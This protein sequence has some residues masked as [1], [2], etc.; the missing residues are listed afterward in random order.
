MRCSWTVAAAALF[1]ASGSSCGSPS[2]LVDRDMGPGLDFASYDAGVNNS[3]AAAA[4]GGTC[5]TT[6]VCANGNTDCQAGQACNMALNPP[7]CQTLHCGADGTPCGA[8]G[9]LCASGMCSQTCTGNCC[10]F[11]RPGNDVG[12]G[13]FCV[14]ASDCAGLQASTCLTNSTATGGFCSMPCVVGMNCGSGAQCLTHTL[15][16]CY[17]TSL[18]STNCT[19]FPTDCSFSDCH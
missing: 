2:S 8:N 16:T 3:D 1:F 4:D 15:M 6:T 19:C 9:N 7:V 11:G 12:V 17:D 5:V 10:Q 18:T 14:T 13:K